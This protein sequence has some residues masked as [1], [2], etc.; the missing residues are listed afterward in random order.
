M[1]LSYPVRERFAT[2]SAAAVS[3]AFIADGRAVIV[4]EAELVLVE[5]VESAQAREGSG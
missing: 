3:C 5:S 2:T 4:T 1:K